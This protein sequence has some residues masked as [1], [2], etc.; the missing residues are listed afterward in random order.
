METSIISRFITETVFTAKTIPAEVLAALSEKNGRPLTIEVFQDL[1]N[2]DY[3][4]LE[5][6][7]SI[8]E[9]YGKKSAQ[10]VIGMFTD[11]SGT[12]PVLK[13]VYH[14]AVNKK[15]VATNGCYL[16]YCDMLEDEKESLII[17]KSGNIIEGTFPNFQRV[18]PTTFT[19]ETEINDVAFYAGYL[20][21]VN[22]LSAC[23]KLG[24]VYAELKDVVFRTDLLY[25]T[26]A[27]FVK[28][29]A[30]SITMRHAIE[31]VSSMRAPVVFESAGLTVVLMPAIRKGDYSNLDNCKPSFALHPVKIG[32]SEITG[33]PGHVLEDFSSE[34]TEYRINILKHNIKHHLIDVI[35]GAFFCITDSEKNPDTK[36]V[37]KAFNSMITL[38]D[39]E[40]ME[41]LRDIKRI[42]TKTKTREKAINNLS[43]FLKFYAKLIAHYNKLY[44]Q[45][46]VN[47]IKAEEIKSTILETMIKNEISQNDIAIID[48]I[49]IV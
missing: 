35:N 45:E 37:V 18:I 47:F 40:T 46:Q 44:G 38:Y 21:S 42:A 2:Q 32:F 27:A 6:L 31:D 17:D 33:I 3:T 49:D 20:K 36:K 13:G 5:K 25:T 43:A 30:K 39:S 10:N 15:L 24:E 19:V 4:L 41:L 22:N 9:E 26:L 14:D 16:A 12:R 48:N 1:I 7:Q 34:M 11:D 8:P 23:V 28:I 29:G